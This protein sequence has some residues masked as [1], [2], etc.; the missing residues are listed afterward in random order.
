MADTRP[1][2]PAL[3]G[4]AAIEPTTAKLRT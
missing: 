2:D 3:L 1:F 4:D